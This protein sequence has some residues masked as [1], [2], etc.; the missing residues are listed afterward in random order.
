MLAPL[1]LAVGLAPAPAPAPEAEVRLLRGQAELFDAEGRTALPRREQL[2]VPGSAVLELAPGAEVTVTWPGR[3]SLTVEGPA[4]LGWTPPWQ[5][6]QGL[7][8][9]V[10]SAAN[11]RLESRGGRSRLEF[12]T[13]GARYVVRR[14]AISIRTLPGEEIEVR[15]DA[16]D[17]LLTSGPPLRAGRARRLAPAYSEP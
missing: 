5:D 12:P 17:P 7:V 4:E 11:L 15:N 13:A 8:W 14:S 1:L 16:G 3:G 2:E 9:R 6:G 10:R